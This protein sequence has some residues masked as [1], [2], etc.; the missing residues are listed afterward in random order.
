[1]QIKIFDHCP[2]E[3]MWVRITVFVDEQGFHDEFD[4]VDKTAIHFVAFDDRG[5]PIATSRVFK[6]DNSGEYFI[7][8]L[9]VVREH[10]K[11]GLGAKMLREAERYVSSVGGKSISLHSQCRAQEFYAKCGFTAHGEIEYEEGCPHV[12]MTKQ[13]A[14][15]HEMRLNAEPFEAIERGEKTIELRLYD[16]KRR[17][18]RVGDIVRFTH[19]ADESRTLERRVIALHVFPSFEELYRTLPLDRCGYTQS[20]ISTAH[21]SDMEAYYSPDEQKKYGVVGIEMEII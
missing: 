2:K 13:V 21:P 5:N 20:N 6:K 1:M 16:E 18:I 19:S 4:E 14:G 15:F 9:A 7:G 17:N 8:R 11:E 3:A 10:R 12:W